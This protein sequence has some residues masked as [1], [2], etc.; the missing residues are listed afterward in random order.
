MN[1]LTALTVLSTLATLASNDFDGF[2]GFAS[3]LGNGPSRRDYSDPHWKK[4]RVV[5]DAVSGGT[6]KAERQRQNHQRTN[7]TK[8]ERK[9]LKGR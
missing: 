6:E 5:D 2:D 3:G 1:K 8:R 9:A 7:L 4:N